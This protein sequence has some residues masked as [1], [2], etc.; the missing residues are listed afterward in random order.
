M[1]R[2]GH[3]V[4]TQRFSL[5]RLCNL[6]S[7]HAIQPSWQDFPPACFCLAAWPGGTR[8][9]GARELVREFAASKFP[10][11]N[12]PKITRSR[13]SRLQGGKKRNKHTARSLVARQ[14]FCRSCNQ[15]KL[16]QINF[17]SFPWPVRSNI[18]RHWWRAGV[19]FSWRTNLSD[20]FLYFPAAYKK[21]RSDDIFSSNPR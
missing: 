11:G 6:I 18:F 12:K 7:T 9:A 10:R 15:N 1:S 20:I 2:A 3:M 19:M 4:V 21:F 5:M 17:L 13:I 16:Q 8:A 14:E